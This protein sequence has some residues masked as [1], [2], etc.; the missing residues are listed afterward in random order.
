L[1]HGLGD[2]NPDVTQTPSQDAAAIDRAIR[3]NVRFLRRLRQRTL[4]QLRM[5]QRPASP[6]HQR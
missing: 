5:L 6:P 1:E 4:G 3:D 2:E